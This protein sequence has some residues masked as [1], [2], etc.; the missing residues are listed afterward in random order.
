MTQR[1]PGRP[2]R[3]DPYPC[4][5]VANCENTTKG[6]AFGLCHPHYMQ[7]RKGL[8]DK[9]GVQLRE[10][11]RVASY[12][13]GAQCAV[14]GCFNRPKVHGLCSG[15][16]QRQAAGLALAAPFGHPRGRNPNTVGCCVPDCG[17]RANNRSM[18]HKHAEQ[19][20]RGILDDQGNRL[21]EP[22]RGGSIK[23]HGPT[24]DP[25]GYVLAR[26]PDGYQGRTRD[27]CRVLEHRLLLEQSLGRLLEDWEIVH[28]RNGVRH[29]NRL[30]NLELMDGR[31]RKGEGHP[32]GHATT[33]EEVSTA[34]DRLRTSDPAAYAEL[35]KGLI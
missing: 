9:E 33:V 12:G 27:G 4:C 16:W 28:H 10:R 21:R 24:L 2:P 31:A 15:H 8:I 13:P 23:V 26:V 3:T 35:V 29:D 19:R 1:Q 32:P 11:L 30:E 6:G 34:L 22:H 5:K 14:E 20:R 18:C 25:H 7:M 17:A